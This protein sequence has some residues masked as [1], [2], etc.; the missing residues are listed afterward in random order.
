MTDSDHVEAERHNETDP[1]Y[2]VQDVID[3]MQGYRH[4]DDQGTAITREGSTLPSYPLN[5]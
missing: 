4:N 1:T 5:A 2:W 3:A